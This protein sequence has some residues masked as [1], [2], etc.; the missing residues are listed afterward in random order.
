[1]TRGELHENLMVALDTLR[2]HKVRSTLTVLG[3]V[4][5]VTSVISVAAIIHGL[6]RFV[7]KR[8]EQIGSRSFFVAR[9]GMSQAF[10]GLTEKY[11]K[12]RYLRHSDSDYLREAC[13][14]LENVT[15]FSS[16]PSGPGDPGSARTPDVRYGNEHVERL[17]LR[18]VEPEYAQAL[19]IFAVAQG[20]FITRDDVDH[21]RPVVVL[22]DAIALA[23]FPRQDPIGRTIRLDGR[24]YQVVGVFEHDPGLFGMPGVDQ[25]VILP[26]S[27]FRK[28]Y[29]E[30]REVMLVFTIQEEADPGAAVNEVIEA[31]R[32]LRRVKHNDENDFEVFSPDFLTT[33]WNQLTGAIALLTAVISSVG[34]LVGGVG[35]MNIMLISVTERTSEIGV[36]KA[37]GARRSDIRAQFLMEAGVVTLLGGVIGIMTAA[38]IAWV[39]R[40]TIPSIPATLSLFW[41]IV[42]VVMSAGTGLFF[43][44]WPANRAAQLDPVACLRYE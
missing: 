42:G 33:M 15:S 29:P 24:P 38:A 25:F 2:T 18:G 8:V 6:N 16:I 27:N 41:V 20:R 37:M 14:S 4:I 40:S 10:G 30:I 31:L 1:M 7:A 26:V 28:N 11:R 36:R 23:L 32:R 44:Y 5:G 22:G 39:V 12:R 35:V 21:A 43:G 34:L 3:I 13:P 19:P 9:I 17:F